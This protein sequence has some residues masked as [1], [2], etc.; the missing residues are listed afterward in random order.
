MKRVMPSIVILALLGCAGGP[1][2]KS[3]PEWIY[4]SPTPDSGYY[5]FTGAGSSGENDQAKAEEIARGVVI[6]AIM[7]YVG[8]K[9]SEQTTAVVKASVNDYQSEVRQSLIRTGSGRLAG[10]QI[11]DKYVE[12]RPGGL[13]VYLLARYGKSDLDGE[14]K[15]IQNLFIQ[16]LAAITD[17][18]NRAKSLASDG[19]YYG[20]AVNYIQAA[21]AAA[22]SGVDNAKVYFETDV[23]AAKQA[24]DLIGLV[25]LNDNLRAAAGAPFAEPFK[26]KVVAGAASTDPGIPGVSI[27]ATYTEIKGDRKQVRTVALKTGAD[28][29]AAFTYPPSDF[30]GSEK[31]TMALD[32]GAYLDTLDGLSKDFTGMVGGLEDIALGKKTIFN[33]TV[34]STAKDVET[35]LCV[36]SLDDS[37]APVPGG[38]FATGIMKALSDAQFTVS[39][40]PLDPSSLAGKADTDVIRAASQ[41]ATG[42]TARVI[43]GTAQLAGTE[44]DGDTVFQKV[45]ATVKVADLASGSILLTVTRIKSAIGSSAAAAQAAALRQLGQDIGQEIAGKLR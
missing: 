37:G 44:K 35:G 18:E 14:K 5:Y 2:A 15:R 6:D 42:K 38:D 11:A 45:S 43:F 17:P 10:L 31:I 34:F 21:A 23:N 25:K 29:V 19:D 41:A 20:A 30:V 32:L 27:N 9:V 1:A 28:G 8:V 16:Q 7:Q 22:K 13:T 40:I 36:A 3:A 4:T 24:L 33:L 12:K 39:A 26:L